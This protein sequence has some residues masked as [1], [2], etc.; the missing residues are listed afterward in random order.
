MDSSN[1][2]VKCLLFVECGVTTI[3]TANVICIRSRLDENRLNIIIIISR[4]SP[5]HV[6]RIPG[7]ILGSPQGP[8]QN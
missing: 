5:L 7:T 6:L 1:S 8:P 2:E 4:I 3:A